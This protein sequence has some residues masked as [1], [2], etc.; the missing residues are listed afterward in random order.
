MLALWTAVAGAWGFGSYSYTQ[1][2]SAGN[3]YEYSYGYSYGSYGDSGE[4][5][6][7]KGQRGLRCGDGS[8]VPG[9][10]GC[11]GRPDCADGSDEVNCSFECMLHDSNMQ[12]YQCADGSCVSGKQRCDATANCPDGSDE[13]GC[14]FECVLPKGGRGVLCSGDSGICLHRS[15]ACD[16]EAGQERFP[17]RTVKR[18]R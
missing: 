12:G 15:R 8:C 3:S 5:D 14:S 7:G 10:K 9:S 13:L 17:V 16:G 1:A 18:T 11:D 2:V 6:L 4:C